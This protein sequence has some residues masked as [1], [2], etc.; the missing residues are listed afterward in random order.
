MTK[1]MSTNTILLSEVPSM[2][3]LS[4]FLFFI[5]VDSFAKCNGSYANHIIAKMFNI[6]NSKEINI[7]YLE[8]IAP[9]AS[10]RVASVCS[11]GC[12]SAMFNS[13]L[14]AECD[15]K[16]LNAIMPD[17]ELIK[18]DMQKK[19]F[20]YNPEIAKNIASDSKCKLIS[21]FEKTTFRPEKRLD[22]SQNSCPENMLAKCIGKEVV[23]CQAK[24]DCKGHEKYGTNIYDVVCS[25]I[26]GECPDVYACAEDESWDK[27]K[28]KAKNHGVILKETGAS[29]Q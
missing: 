29:Q 16:Y 26:D 15:Q 5:S 14:D 23:R 28:E 25:A 10:K 13:E 1:D 7:S 6:S 17:I 27:F 22:A 8:S 2:K 24:I 12:Y 4:F 21:Q 11:S 20:T 3:L 9:E 18:G 19:G